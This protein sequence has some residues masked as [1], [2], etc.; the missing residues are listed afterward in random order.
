ML[1]C[2]VV[3]LGVVMTL[4]VELVVDLAGE[5]LLGGGGLVGMN[6]GKPASPPP[7]ST[8][9][10]AVVLRLSSMRSVSTNPL[11]FCLALSLC[12]LI[13]VMSVSS[14]TCPARTPRS[15]EKGMMLLSSESSMTPL[16]ALAFSSLL[17]WSGRS[18]WSACRKSN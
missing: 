3:D 2:L 17:W 13:T 12:R 16:A 18:R 1:A 14:K 4:V 15:S 7:S 11:K 6:T 10:L 5:T 9:G 8:D